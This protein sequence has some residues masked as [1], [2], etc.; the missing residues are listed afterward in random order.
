M[1]KFVEYIKSHNFLHQQDQHF[2]CI[3]FF[4]ES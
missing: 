1:V 3:V 4:P 2:Y